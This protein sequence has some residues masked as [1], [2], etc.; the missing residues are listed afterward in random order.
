MQRNYRLPLGPVYDRPP[1][2][3]KVLVANRG[4]IALRIVR[5]W[6][7]VGVPCVAV[8]AD[9]DVARPHVHAADRTVALNATG[10]AAYLMAR[11]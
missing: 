6:H 1:L 2:F 5:A 11:A 3:A 8:Y 7:D 4:E 10:P 9:D